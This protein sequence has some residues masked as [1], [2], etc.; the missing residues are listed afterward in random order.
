MVY[1]YK[2]KNYPESPRATMIN[3]L[4]S[5]LSTM[6]LY[7][8]IIIVIIGVSEATFEAI[9]TGAVFL[10]IYF[11]C[12]KNKDNWTD[13]MAMNQSGQAAPQQ[14][15][16]FTQQSQQPS[17]TQQPSQAQQPQVPKNNNFCPNCGT[18]LTTAS[19]FCPSC[20]HKLA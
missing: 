2:Y 4:I 11:F 8:G 5:M 16:A 19:N 17:Q 10:A 7:F 13:K 9:A 18:K 6:L 12:K 1:F 20:G 15:S 3:K 14:P